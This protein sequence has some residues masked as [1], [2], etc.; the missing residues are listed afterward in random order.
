MRRW[1]TI[2]LLVFLPVQLSWAAAA[3]YCR[4]EGG[5]STKHYG[6]HEH[7]HQSAKLKAAGDERADKNLGAGQLDDDC[8][9]CQL[10]GVQPVSPTHAVA[11]AVPSEFFAPPDPRAYESHLADLSPRPD[12]ALDR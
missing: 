2:L 10:S 8:G 1:L 11:F 12:R 9:V 5:S 4:H 3:S 6:H 7:E